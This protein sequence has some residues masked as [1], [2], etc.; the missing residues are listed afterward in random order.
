MFEFAAS[1][2]EIQH[3]LRQT[4]V[5]LGYVANKKKKRVFTRK[6]FQY[7]YLKSLLI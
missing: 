4:D 1:E 6:E 5:V 2:V 7:S 3:G